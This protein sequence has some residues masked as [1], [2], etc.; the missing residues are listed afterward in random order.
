[1]EEEKLNPLDELTPSLF[2]MDALRR[3]RTHTNTHTFAA[4]YFLQRSGRG[5]RGW[6]GLLHA[7]GQQDAVHDGQPDPRVVAAHGARA[8]VIVGR[9]ADDCGGEAARHS[10]AVCV[11]RPG[12]A[13]DCEGRGRHGAAGLREEVADV[14]AQQERA[15]DCLC[16]RRVL[17]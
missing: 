2:G 9:C 1:M 6:K 12:H 16:C 3:K 8:P 5:L 7:E 4:P 10:G 17:K 14:V 13:G 11:V 15:M